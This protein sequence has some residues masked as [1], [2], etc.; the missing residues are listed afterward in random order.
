[1]IVV[2]AACGCKLGNI[3]GKLL[4]GWRM[5]CD[6]CYNKRYDMPDFLKGIFK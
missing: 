1:M 3:Q 4:K 6:K 5:L 2:C